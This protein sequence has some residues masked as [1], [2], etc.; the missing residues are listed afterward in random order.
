MRYSLAIQLSFSVLALITAGCGGGGSDYPGE[1]RYPVSGTVTFQGEPVTGGTISLVADDEKLNPSG[2]S[3]ENGEFTIPEVKGPNK[4]AYRIQVYWNKPTGKTIID[5]EDTGEEIAV[6]E[7]VI[8]AQYNDATEL[9][10]TITGN[11][12]TDKID[13]KL[14]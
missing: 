7:Q 8:P 14:D 13:L 9:T 11:A 5:T 10:H 3:I 4:G 1:Q 6:V 12:E 2:A